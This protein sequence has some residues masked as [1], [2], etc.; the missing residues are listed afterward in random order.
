[1]LLC[2]YRSGAMLRATYLR[3]LMH[4]IH[5]PIAI[6]ISRIHCY[7]RTFRFVRAVQYGVL[8]NTLLPDIAYYIFPVRPRK[9]Y[10]TGLALHAALLRPML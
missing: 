6:R 10:E 3:F 1:M 2:I 7:A 4:C 9:T 5:S 8:G